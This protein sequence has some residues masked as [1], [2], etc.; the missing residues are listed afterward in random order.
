MNIAEA[1]DMLGIEDVSSLTKKGL[2]KVYRSLMKKNHPDKGGNEEVAKKINAAYELAVEF[3]KQLEIIRVAE[4]GMVEKVCLIDFSS[5]LKIYNGETIQIQS[6]GNTIPLSRDNIWKFRV[7]L[8]TTIMLDVCGEIF[9]YNNILS[10]NSDDTYTFL[11]K[12][13]VTNLED[14]IPIT[15][16]AYGKEVSLNLAELNINLTMK[17][18]CGI[19][20]RVCIERQLI[21]NGT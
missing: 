21:D 18:V 14:I 2:N 8:D 9:K 1:L 5:F 19:K 3:C 13:K 4:Q 17:F 10:R 15:I 7:L 20:I 11:C 6:D 16:K 12:V